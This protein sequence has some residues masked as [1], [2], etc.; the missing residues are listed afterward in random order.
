[1]TIYNCTE[2]LKDMEEQKKPEQEVLT[3]RHEWTREEMEEETRDFTDRFTDT[4]VEAVAMMRDRENGSVSATL[5]SY[6][7][8]GQMVAMA[9]KKDDGI[10]VSVLCAVAEHF[11]EE[12]LTALAYVEPCEKEDGE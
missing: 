8:F 9:M 11:P 5:G 12:M 1:M 4:H 6:S 10:K 7:S 2:K 3:E